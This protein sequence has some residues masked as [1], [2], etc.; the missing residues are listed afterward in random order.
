MA[1]ISTGLFQFYSENH[2]IQRI[3][4]TGDQNI[5]TTA[6]EYIDSIT[7]DHNLGYYPFVRVWAENDNGDIGECHSDGQAPWAA[8]GEPWQNASAYYYITT[9]QLIIKLVNNSASTQ[10][11]RVY[12]RIYENAA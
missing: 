5:E 8:F 1:D 6:V 12:W 11:R 4:A 7:I 3:F 2:D 10:T 9:T